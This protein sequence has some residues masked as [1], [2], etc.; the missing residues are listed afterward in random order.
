MKNIGKCIKKFSREHAILFSTAVTVMTIAIF[1]LIIFIEH[2]L[3][4]SAFVPYSGVVNEGI[5]AVLVCGFLCWTGYSYI[6][7][8]KCMSFGKGLIVGM[9]V[10]VMSLIML[11][12]GIMVGMGS[13]SMQPWHLILM[14]IIEFGLTGIVE[15]FIFR[16]VVA[17]SLL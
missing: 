1:K 9:F 6:F 15:E 11:A 10:V 3:A 13:A 5:A 4:K 7:K 16:G 12:A 14:S 8:R 17:E 2:P